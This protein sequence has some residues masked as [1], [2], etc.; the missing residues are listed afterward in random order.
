[1]SDFIESITGERVKDIALFPFS[2]CNPAFY[3]EI[4]SKRKEKTHMVVRGEQQNDLEVNDADERSLE[5]EIFIYKLLQRLGLNN[6]DVKFHGRIFSVP[7]YDQT[8]DVVENFSFFIMDYANGI[9]ADRKIK[10]DSIKEKLSRFD[11]I[12]KVYALLHENSGKVYGILG[13]SGFVKNAYNKLEEFLLYLLRSKALLA[14]KLLD[15]TLAEEVFRFCNTTIP[16]FCADLE[17]SGYLP[18]PRL[19]LY[20]GFAG[21]ML[22]S[23]DFISLIDM[24][25]VGYYEPATDFSPFIFSLKNILFIQTGEGTFWDYFLSCYLKYGGVLPE[26]E[27]L[28]QMILIMTVNLALHNVIYCKN[29]LGASKRKNTVYM[30]R[31]A[32][33]L[34]SLTSPDIKQ[35][36]RA[37][38]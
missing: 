5:K 19:G 24:D 33:S 35:I 6:V 4:E 30:I 3:I 17:S 20:D 8:C 37:M 22:I 29:H 38:D 7:G 32:R 13:S 10:T 25:L 34:M 36:V 27:L 11:Q 2:S 31:L 12:A 14:A 9:A 1:M 21:N 26:K 15:N 28:N 23:D 18:Q 16:T